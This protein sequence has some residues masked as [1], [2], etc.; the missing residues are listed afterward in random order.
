[1]AG[2]GEKGEKKGETD[3]GEGEG[4]IVCAARGMAGGGRGR[5]RKVM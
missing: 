3:D 2:N 1:M 5:D 4:A